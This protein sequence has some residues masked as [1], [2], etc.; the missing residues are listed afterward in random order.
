[1]KERTDMQWR[2]R[3]SSVVF[4]S[5]LLSAILVAEDVVVVPLHATL[6]W[7]GSVPQNVPATKKG[8]PAK[9][10][11]IGGLD[12]VLELAPLREAEDFLKLRC[13]R[14]ISVLQD[15]WPEVGIVFGTNI[16]HESV[17][18][19]RQDHV[20]FD[21]PDQA[22]LRLSASLWN[23]AA[24]RDLAELKVSSEARNAGIVE[25]YHVGRLS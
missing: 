23:G 4:K 19:D 21:R 13:R 7:V 2:L 9:T 22:Q 14:L 16:S 17:R 8:S 1:M 25:G 20:L 5:K 24:G 11:L 12:P 3:G 6:S 15:H 10:L 18:L